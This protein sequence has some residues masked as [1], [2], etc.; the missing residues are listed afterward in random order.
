VDAI[1]IY[2]GTHLNLN[3]SQQKATL[4]CYS[5]FA[6]LVL[7]LVYN[8]YDIGGW[9]AGWL[10]G[11]LL[12]CGFCVPLRKIGRTAET[13]AAFLLSS[14]SGGGDDDDD[15]DDNNNDNH[16]QRVCVVCFCFCLAMHDES[17][18]QPGSPGAALLLGICYSY[19]KQPR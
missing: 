13:A 14:V 12:D 15:D 1:T 10:A 6:I 16:Q 8:I 3:F 7:I 18:P 9:L 4:Y 5:F 11:C 2:D 19:Y 17:S